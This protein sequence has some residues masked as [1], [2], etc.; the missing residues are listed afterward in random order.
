MESAGRGVG[1][2]AVMHESAMH[3]AQKFAADYL[4]RTTMLHI[5]DVGSM[6]VSPH[7]PDLSLRAVFD[8]WDYFG[9]DLAPGDNVDVV[10]KSGPFPFHR[11]TFDVTASANAFEHD[12]AFWRT[13]DEM[14]RV[15]KRDG[16]IL[17]IAPSRGDYHAHPK[18]YWRFM[19]DA[20]LALADW[21]RRAELLEHY[22]QEGTTWRDCVAVFRIIG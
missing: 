10:R 17:L 7:R 22:M 19:D 5:L 9:M 4:D 2:G 14:V 15:T 16:L 3:A 20:P 1:V 8:H 18:D 11:G 12:W 6:N 21:N 13:F